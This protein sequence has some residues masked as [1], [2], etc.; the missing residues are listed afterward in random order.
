M[1]NDIIPHI[2]RVEDAFQRYPGKKPGE[3]NLV[4]N[5]VTLRVDQGEFLTVVGPTGCGKSTLL[6]MIL[7]SESPASGKVIIGGLE[8]REPSLKCGVV[9]QQ[10][11]LYPNLTVR[12]NVMRGLEFKEFRSLDCLFHPFKLC[13]KRKGEFRQISDEY[14]ERVG[15][16]EHAEKYPF[17]LS[18]GMRQRAAI[19]QAMALKPQ[20]LLMDEP[21]GALDVGTREAMQLF[22]LEQWDCA[23]QTIIFVTHDL[24]EALFL[25]SRL[26]VLSQF[27]SENDGSKGVG[28]KV[29]KD[30]SL[31][32]P[33]PRPTSLKH[34]ESFNKIMMS[35][36]REGFDPSYLQKVK[37]F[38]LTHEDAAWYKTMEGWKPEPAF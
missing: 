32:W 23:N 7:G 5:D 19:A 36:R 11:S 26:V 3:Y 20:V 13:K 1:D 21:L 35:V 30:I 27:W 15:L 6:R 33:L 2:L 31:D 16:L 29:V 14:L 10:Y 4:V 37:E 17:E 38:D 12:G 8:V 18:G 28:A 25:G 22:I 34:S 9:F 24:E